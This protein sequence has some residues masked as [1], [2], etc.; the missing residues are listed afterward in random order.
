MPRHCPFHFISRLSTCLSSTWAFIAVAATMHCSPFPLWVR[1]PLRPAVW[2]FVPLVQINW[3]RVT[4]HLR[5]HISPFSCTASCCR[6]AYSTPFSAVRAPVLAGERCARSTGVR[7]GHIAMN[8]PRFTGNAVRYRIKSRQCVSPPFAPCVMPQEQM[9]AC[10]GYL[11]E[12]NIV[13]SQ[14]I[15][16][17]QSAGFVAL[18]HGA[19]YP[20]ARHF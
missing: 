16:G 17:E 9:R 19:R 1:H 5:F 2:L 12:Q 20:D 11:L 14:N 7:A 6:A 15:Y 10:D 13:P 4:P 3:C 18:L 8:T